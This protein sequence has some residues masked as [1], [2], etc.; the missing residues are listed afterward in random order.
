VSIGLK[1]LTKLPIGSLPATSEED[2]RII[3]AL[4]R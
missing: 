3:K 1:E 2:R 4:G